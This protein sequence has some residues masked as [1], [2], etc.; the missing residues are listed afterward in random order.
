MP[1]VLVIGATCNIG[2]SAVQA[3]LRAG[4]QVPAVVRNKTSADKLFKN[5]GTVEGITTVEADI[6]SD[7]GVKVVVD[8]VRKGQLPAF[9]H[10]Y[11]AGQS[12]EDSCVV[13]EARNDTNTH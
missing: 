1:T 12:A 8:K 3:T 10:V 13:A 6:M 4:F 9:E 7:E 11:S 5:L 2:T